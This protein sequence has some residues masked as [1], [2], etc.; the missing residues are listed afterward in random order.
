VSWAEL[1]AA[2]LVAAELVVPDFLR[3]LSRLARGKLGTTAF[4]AVGPFY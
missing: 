1:V 2:E 3:N 4:G